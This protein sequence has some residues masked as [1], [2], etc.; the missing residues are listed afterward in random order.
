MVHGRDDK[1]SLP[2]SACTDDKAW[3]WDPVLAAQK[4]MSFPQLQA[5]LIELAW[6]VVDHVAVQVQGQTACVASMPMLGPLPCHTSP[7][8][9]AMPSGASSSTTQ[10]V[11]IGAPSLPTACVLCVRAV[12]EA[13][14]APKAINLPL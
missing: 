11:A 4:G 8:Y 6:R 10:T 5:V 9:S 3:P 1:T 14:R 12:F 7:E 13:Q 2:L